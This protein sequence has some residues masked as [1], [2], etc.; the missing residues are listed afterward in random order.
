MARRNGTLDAHDTTGDVH[1][2]VSIHVHVCTVYQRCGW[3]ERCGGVR[4]VVE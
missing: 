3:C 1:L 4:G 2:Y